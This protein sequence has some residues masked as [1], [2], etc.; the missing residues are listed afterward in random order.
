MKCCIQMGTLL[1]LTLNTDRLSSVNFI[2][3][4]KFIWK[5]AYLI[6]T[7]TY[8]KRQQAI[9]IDMIRVTWASIPNTEKK[10]INPAD[11]WMTLRLPTLVSANRP[12]FSLYM[13]QITIRKGNKRPKCSNARVGCFPLS[14]NHVSPYVYD[15]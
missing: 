3:E 1:I 11:I 13:K 9:S 5:S 7:T 2:L 6:L 14:V 10:I 4:Q 8:Y 12:A 15:S